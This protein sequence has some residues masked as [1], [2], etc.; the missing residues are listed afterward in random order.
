MDRKATSSG[1]AGLALAGAAAVLATAHAA[2]AV[3]TGATTTYVVLMLLHACAYL[4]AA[5]LVFRH[6][7]TARARLLGILAVALLLRGIAMTA[8]PNLSTDAYRY[9]WDGRIQAAGFNPYV[10]VPADPRLARLRD[11]TIYPN[12][13]QKERAVTIY[14]PA[15]Q[16]LFRAAHGLTDG[17]GG[18]RA[19][20]LAADLVV[21]L[22]LLALLGVLRLPSDR[23][24]L[25]AWHPLPVWE[26]C[27]QSH[28]DAAMT[29]AVTL[30]LVAVAAGRRALA[31]AML[32]VAT[33]M[34]FVPLVLVPALWRRWDWRAPLAFLVTAVTLSLPYALQAGRGLGGFLGKHLDNEG[35]VAGWGF[36]PVWLL[37]DVGLP[38]PDGTTY[39]VFAAA[40]MAGLGLWALLARPVDAIRWERVLLLA[41]TATW[42]AS[43]HYPWY[44]AMLVPL[45]AIVPHPAAFALT[46]LAPVLYLPRPPGGI[47]WTEIYLV[48]YWLPLAVLLAVEGRR[49]RGRAIGR[50][51]AQRPTRPAARE[52]LSTR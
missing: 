43:P 2:T 34:K 11:A 20:M 21:L 48:V 19:V 6:V 33:L 35:Y 31:G 24:L 49:L 46:L 30:C 26:F 29:A 47:T 16:W 9:V 52:M 1:N 12:I 27:A 38:A 36:H 18:V 13:N 25:Y 8:E 5:G 44:F 23:V 14:P 15:A 17:L 10:M 37:R 28:I 41:A 39:A 32:A 4:V 42:L 22:A 50:T 3:D 51:P 40:I 45:L 7:S